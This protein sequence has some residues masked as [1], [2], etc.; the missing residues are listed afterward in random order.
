MS[1]SV[2]KARKFYLHPD[3]R[4][5]CRKFTKTRYEKASRNWLLCV[6]REIL[7]LNNCYIYTETLLFHQKNTKTRKL[8]KY[9]PIIVNICSYRGHKKDKKEQKQCVLISLHPG[10]KLAPIRF[11]QFVPRFCSRCRLYN[12][13]V[14]RCNFLLFHRTHH[15]Q[16]S[17]SKGKL[18]MCIHN[19]PPHRP[20]IQN[21]GLFIVINVR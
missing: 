15:F 5:F 8:L 18:R 3:G 2:F 14:Q 20:S 10:L 13:Y 1:S 17:C 19:P 6:A 11:V 21:G 7:E 4:Y 12:L 9:I 16:A